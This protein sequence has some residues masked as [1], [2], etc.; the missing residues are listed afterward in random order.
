MKSLRD[1]VYRISS[2]SHFSDEEELLENTTMWSHYADN[3]RGFCVKYKLDFEHSDFREIL[4]CGLF[5]VRY[6]AKT[7]E[8]TANQLSTKRLS[9]TKRTTTKKRVVKWL[10]PKTYIKL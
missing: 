7:E 5:P 6:R 4:L 2:F 8:I 10:P 1:T 3:H 9:K